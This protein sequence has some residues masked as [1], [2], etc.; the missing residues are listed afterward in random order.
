[1]F[2]GKHR[3][4]DDFGLLVVE[5]ISNCGMP[6]V[7]VSVVVAGKRDIHSYV[8]CTRVC[9]RVCVYV[10]VCVIKSCFNLSLLFNNWKKI[11]VKKIT[12]NA[13]FKE[14]KGPVLVIL[15]HYAQRFLFSS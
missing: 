6:A 7:S 9:M 4:C 11:E 14:K 12:F 15:R 5:D 13:F 8:L 3:G 1:M 10:Y 2:V